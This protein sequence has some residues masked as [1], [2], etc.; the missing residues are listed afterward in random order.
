MHHQKPGFQLVW[1]R[2]GADG[3]LPGSVWQL[4]IEGGASW[5]GGLVLL[6]DL[7]ALEAVGALCGGASGQRGSS[8]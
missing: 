8:G 5:D 1:N 3:A 7:L 4:P 6:E 2:V